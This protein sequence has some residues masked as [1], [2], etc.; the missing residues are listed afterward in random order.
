VVVEI[1]L[2]RCA[3]L[4]VHRQT[5]MAAVRTPDDA[6]GRREQVQ[7]FTTFTAGLRQ[8]REWLSDNGV[9]QVAT[10]ATGVDFFE[11]RNDAQRRQRYLI[12]ELEKLGHTVVLDPA[13]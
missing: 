11:P 8:L 6:G 3:G 12:R 5:V 9:T 13:P 4:V 2:S 1:I 7:Q 10:E